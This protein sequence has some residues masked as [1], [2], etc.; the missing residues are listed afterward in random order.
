MNDMRYTMIFMCE[1]FSKPA[2]VVLTDSGAEFS[3]INS[4]LVHKYKLQ[5]HKPIGSA[6][7]IQG[8]SADMETKRRGY[9]MLNIT[10]H[11]GVASGRQA[12]SFRK[13]FEI[14]DLGGED[15]IVGADLGPVLF[16]EDNTWK[17]GAKWAKH[18][19]TW[20]TNIVRHHLHHPR[21]AVLNAAE[22]SDDEMENEVSADISA[23]F[24]RSLSDQEKEKEVDENESHLSSSSSS[25]SQSD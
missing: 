2:T 3:A 5:V 11:Y 16:P 10:A 22:D 7:H 8:A 19:T 20:P 4:K 15:F 25:F 12:V 14:L 24:I 1:R 6:T 18:M 9:V 17:H 21:A 13:Q 23:G